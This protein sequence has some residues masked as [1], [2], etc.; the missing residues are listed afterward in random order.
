M[1][2]PAEVDRI[3]AEIEKL[4]KALRRCTDGGIRGQ[5]I[6][7]IEKEKRKLTDEAEKGSA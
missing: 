3:K 5:I 4:E 6:T 1:L 7:W 2:S